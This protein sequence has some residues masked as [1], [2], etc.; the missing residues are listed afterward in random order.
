M[1]SSFFCATSMAVST[2]YHKGYKHLVRLP[3]HKKSKE[4]KR[5]PS[6]KSATPVGSPRGGGEKT[7][8]SFAALS[9]K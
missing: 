3:G 6:G 4:R 5:C 2:G 1:K 8:S 9:T 7:S